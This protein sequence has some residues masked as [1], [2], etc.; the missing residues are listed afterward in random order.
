MASKLKVDELEGVTTAGSIDV[1]SEGGSTTTNLQQGLAKAWANFNGTGTIA[2]RD[3]FN[4]ST[5]DDNGTGRYDVN[6]T[7]NFANS[8]YVPNVTVGF[9]ADTGR[10]GEVTDYKSSGEVEVGAR[11]SGGSSVDNAGIAVAIQGDLA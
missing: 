11:N 9:S 7:N 1:T 6:T 10:Y 5:L 4:V 8:D 3:S 2:E